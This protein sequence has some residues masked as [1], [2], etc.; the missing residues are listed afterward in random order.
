MLV[1]SSRNLR[2]D[3]HLCFHQPCKFICT[4]RTS[5]TGVQKYVRPVDRQYSA[6]FNIVVICYRHWGPETIYVSK[7]M[8]LS[9]RTICEASPVS[10]PDP[11]DSIST[12]K[13]GLKRRS[14]SLDL[15]VRQYFV[16]VD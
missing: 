8:R 10:D 15:D 7:A 13:W 14:R 9:D 6:L 4:R 16:Y 12:S 5:T 3:L 2:Q 11:E 1:I